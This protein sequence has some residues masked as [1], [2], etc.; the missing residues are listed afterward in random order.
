MHCYVGDKFV[1]RDQS[2]DLTLG[3]GEIVFAEK[4]LP[5]RRNSMR[6]AQIIESYETGTPSTCLIPYLRLGQSIWSIFAAFGNSLLK[7]ALL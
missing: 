6:R 5:K 2:L 7:R 1:L 3:G 4:S